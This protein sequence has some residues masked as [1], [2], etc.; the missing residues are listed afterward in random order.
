MLTKQEAASYL[1]LR[2]F[3][4]TAHALAEHA[5][6][7][8]GPAHSVVNGYLYYSR[9]DLDEWAQMRRKCVERR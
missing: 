3:A 2:H 1:S 4:M 6:R 5:K 8:N 9:D 7:G